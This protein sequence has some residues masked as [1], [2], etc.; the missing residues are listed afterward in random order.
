MDARALGTGM[1]VVLGL[2]AGCGSSTS[3][4]WAKPGATEE[5]I[6]RD[7]ADCLTAARSMAPGGREG[8]RMVVDQNRY[9][10]CMV[11]RGYTAGPSR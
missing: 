4:R 9:R 3:E 8:P 5:Q 10:Q 2:F 11:N 1:L 6:N 7:S